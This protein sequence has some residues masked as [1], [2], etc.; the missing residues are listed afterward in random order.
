MMSQAAPSRAATPAAYATIDHPSAW[1]SAAIGGAEGLSRH[2]S[3]VQQAAL[4]R[5]AEAVAEKPLEAITRADADT[6]EIATLMQAVRYEIMAGKGAVVLRGLDISGLSEATFA[7]LYFALGTHLGEAAVQ[8]AKRDRIGRVERLDDNPAA[9]GYQMDIE[10]GGHCDFHEILSLASYRR[11]AAG[12]ES[13]LVSAL[14]IHNE[15]ARE[16]PDLLAALYRGFPHVCADLSDLT[17]H[18]VPVFCNV[19]GRVSCYYHML[20][21][22][23]AARETGRPM[24][25]DLREALRMVGE[26]SNREDLKASFMLEPG[27][28]VFWHN[29]INLHSRTAF[30]DEGA[31]K[32]LL[33]RL[34]LHTRPGEGRPMDPDFVGRARLMDGIHEQGRPAIVYKLEE[35]RR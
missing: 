12:G 23:N 26:L 35:L 1:T 11:S 18:D 2:L 19:E 33:F 7:R 6:P 4:L 28:I 14:A 3:P 29:F 17:D 31:Q 9:R 20:F 16:R 34:W 15:M 27:E 13:G 10:L 5:L 21:F 8:S 25:D 32:R 24:P 30:T 22:V